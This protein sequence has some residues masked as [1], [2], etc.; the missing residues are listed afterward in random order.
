MQVS[1]DIYSLNENFPSELTVF[2]PRPKD[3]VTKISTPVMRNPLLS[4]YLGLPK[5]LPKQYRLLLLV[6]PP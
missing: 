5:R 1:V 4:F 3:H 2:L 6:P